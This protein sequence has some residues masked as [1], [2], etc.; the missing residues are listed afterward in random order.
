LL[1]DER[2]NRPAGL[3]QFYH[4][5]SKRSPSTIPSVQNPATPDRHAS[6]VCYLVALGSKDRV[7]HHLLMQRLRALA[8]L[9]GCLAVLAGGFLTVAAAAVPSSPP[10]TE[11]SAMGEPCSHCEDCG[12]TSCP[13]PTATCLQACTSVAPSLA[14]VSFRLPAIETGHASWSLHTTILSGLSPPPDPFPPR[15]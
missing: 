12:N 2:A 9:L 11:R 14:V 7:E 1:G 3:P 6:R 10:P 8:A 4:A 15:A 5:R 13:A